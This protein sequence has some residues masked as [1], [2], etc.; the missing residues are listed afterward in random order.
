MD[1]LAPHLQSFDV[2]LSAVEGHRWCIDWLRG[3]D[4]RFSSVLNAGCNIGHETISLLWLLGAANAIGI[5]ID[6][7]VIRQANDR[8]EAL[9]EDIRQL[10]GA[11]DRKIPMPAFME[12]RVLSLLKD[13][14]HLA[15]PTYR[16]ADITKDIDL[17]TSS[18]D[19]VY[20]HK[21]LYLLACPTDTQSSRATA[22]SAIRDLADL[23]ITEGLFVAIEPLTC[24]PDDTTSVD[25]SELFSAAGLRQLYDCESLVGI[26][27]RR[28]YCYEKT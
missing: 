27:E 3:L 16:V 26:E 13:Y 20:C 7:Q 23:L 2:T 6:A 22:L 24:S 10:R 1:N 4:R 12:E 21:V 9:V 15:L 14:G 18:Y 17:P 25:L 19:L 28:V 8:I 11:I 5:D